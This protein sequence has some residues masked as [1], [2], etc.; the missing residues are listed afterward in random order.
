M[1]DLPSWT[2]T[3]AFGLSLSGITAIF[4]LSAAAALRDDFQFF[5]PPTKQSWKHKAFLFL[6]RLFLYPLVVLTVL[7]LESSE[8]SRALYEYIFGGGL[9][10][11]GF[12]MAFKITFHMG[13]RNAFGEDRGLVTTGWFSRSRNPVYIFTWLGLIGWTVVAQSLLVTILLL[14]WALLY[15][16]APIFEEPW[17]EKQYGEAYREYRRNV[18]RFFK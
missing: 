3:V 14:A 2:H 5:P 6:F 8:R 1:F 18:P 7:V 15:L 17:L 11:I 10:F 13:W 12:G 4:G 9:I 16:F